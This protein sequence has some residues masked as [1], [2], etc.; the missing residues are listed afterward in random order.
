LWGVVP[1]TRDE[2]LSSPRPARWKTC[3]PINV[4]K[5]MP[6]MTDHIRY[7]AENRESIPD[8][9]MGMLDKWDPLLQRSQMNTVTCQVP[10]TSANVG[11]GF[12]A[13]GVAVSLYN[14]VTV[15][16]TD[17]P[18]A[19]NPFYQQAADL[20]FQTAGLPTSG[21]AVSVEGDVPRSRGLG[22]SVTVRLGMLMAL[23]QLHGSPLG[24]EKILQLTIQLEGHPD[25]AVAAM[26]GGFCITD[27]DTHY[28]TDVSGSLKFIAIIPGH[29]METAAAREV[30]PKRIDFSEAIENIQH[31][32]LI[33]AAFASGNY[34]VL[35]GHF[36]DK[37]HQP[38]RLPLMPGAMEA[39]EAAENAGA[40]GA[41]LSGAGSTLMALT[42]EKEQEV[43]TAMCQALEQAGESPPDVHHLI[44]DNA[45]ARIL[46]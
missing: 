12:D 40:L 21:Y 28:H 27:G 8:W 38:Y 10:A 39:I 33:S 34:G 3:A 13:L 46:N 2:D 37:L 16:P 14:R 23:N 24:E 42:L 5:L 6:F 44:A 29:S 15:S 9:L 4:L 35:R 11:P 45:G 32:A 19:P 18:P 7:H 31:A 41:Y 17:S 26:L 22:S 36:G 1:R 30:L 43:A 20:F 25:N